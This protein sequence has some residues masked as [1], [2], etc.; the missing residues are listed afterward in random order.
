MVNSVPAVDRSDSVTALRALHA[1]SDSIE[2][3]RCA[4]VVP[5][6]SAS[7]DVRGLA[8]GGPDTQ[9]MQDVSEAADADVHGKQMKAKYKRAASRVRNAAE[10]AAKEGAVTAVCTI[11][12]LRPMHGAEVL[13]Q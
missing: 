4:A 3:A 10:L 7:R 2:V 11:I 8:A 13:D 6:A 9:V 1:A 12:C 5:T